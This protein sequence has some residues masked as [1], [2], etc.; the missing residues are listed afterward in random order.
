MPDLPN[1]TA[2]IPYPAS[3]RDCLVLS[4]AGE[5]LP[6]LLHYRIPALIR[7]RC[8]HT[9]PGAFL[10]HMRSNQRVSSGGMNSLQNRN[11]GAMLVW[12]CRSRP[13]V[14][15]RAKRSVRYPYRVL[16]GYPTGGF[17]KPPGSRPEQIA[18]ASPSRESLPVRYEYESPQTRRWSWRRL[19][20]PH[21][22]DC[23]TTDA[24]REDE[25]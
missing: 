7:I 15:L 20:S 12:A 6:S 8:C 16:P 22:G 18:R 3:L 19:A 13:L 17:E 14:C 2:I 11:Y 23:R 1:R 9:P 4:C 21:R 25:G 5:P 24:S 10:R